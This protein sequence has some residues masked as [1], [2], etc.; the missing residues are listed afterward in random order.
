MIF[1][2]CF[3][4]KYLH[5]FKHALICIAYVVKSNTKMHFTRL[6]F[7][8]RRQNYFQNWVWKFWLFLIEVYRF[9]SEISIWYYFWLLNVT[10]DDLIYIFV[11]M[12]IMFYSQ[13]WLL[14]LTTVSIVLYQLDHH[15]WNFR[16]KSNIRSIF[17]KESWNSWIIF[18]L[19]ILTFV[20][21]HYQV[22]T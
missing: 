10:D 13:Y 4:S 8:K 2:V 22:E 7:R 18:L 14:F 5:M 12:M 21:I 17:Q 15:R 9:V 1:D 6:I 19:Q 3:A 11:E 20:F 16:Y